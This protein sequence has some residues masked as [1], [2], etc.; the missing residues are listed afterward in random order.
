MSISQITDQIYVGGLTPNWKEEGM[1]KNLNLSGQVIEG[2]RHLPLKD[3]TGNKP[4]AIRKAMRIL[5]LMLKDKNSKVL[6]NCRYGKSRSPLIVALYLY[7][8][9]FRSSFDKALDYV[10]S[11]REQTE[12]NPNLL[13]EIREMLPKITE[14][15]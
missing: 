2:S 12:I 9:G 8:T 13:S 15:Q 3:G 11:K 6:V 5:D 14:S 4:E 1:N 7:K 10:A